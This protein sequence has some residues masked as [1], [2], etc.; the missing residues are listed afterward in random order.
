MFSSPRYVG[1]MG[2]SRWFAAVLGAGACL[3]SVA[4]ASELGPLRVGATHR[5]LE[6]AG[7]TP[8]FYLGDT[9]W[10]LLSRLSRDDTSF[11]LANRAAKGFSV[12]Q[13]VIIAP[14]GGLTVPNAEGDLPLDGGDLARPNEAYFRHVDFVVNRAA[15]LELFM[16][17][18][19]AWGQYWRTTGG[20]S[21]PLFTVE[22]AR[23]FGLFLGRRY[24]TQPVIWILGG[25]Q[26][27]HSPEERAIIDA[28]AA[29]LRDGDGGTHLIT[30]HPRGPGLSSDSLEDA[31]WLDFH[32]VQSSHAGHDH[33]NGLFIAHDRAL[34]PPKPTLDGEPRYE[35]IPVGFYF[36]DANRL[37]RFDDYDVRQAA[38]WALL[39]GACGHTYGNN[40]VWQFWQP[41][42]EPAISANLSWRQSLDTPGAFQMGLLR[43]LFESRPFTRLVPDQSILVDAPRDG[44]AKVRAAR[45]SDGS[46]AFIYSPRGEHFTVD[47]SVFPARR[48]RQIWWDPRYGCAY[49]V[50]TAD[51]HG[52]Q[53]YTPPTSGRG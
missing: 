33:D 49:L 2:R 48:L 18:L 36:A 41:G 12:I 31:P 16:G 7:G 23:G 46:F 6:R 26:D 3:G 10:T 22:K 52:F 51:T 47:Q 34:Q 45:A 13:A 42:R 27:I 11:Y 39:A 44:G 38:Y 29:G 40:N 35:C 19:P 43:R 8:F 21:P 20:G 37:D 15:E 4:T 1:R 32:M 9:A 50:H 5:F 24:R 53:T 14:D 28:L 17:L 30:F 25:D